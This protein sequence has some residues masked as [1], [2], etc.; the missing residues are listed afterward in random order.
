MRAFR[1]QNRRFVVNRPTGAHKAK[2]IRVLFSRASLGFND[3]EDGSGSRTGSLIQL[4][5]I[6]ELVIFTWARS[7]RCTRVI[8]DSKGHSQKSLHVFLI[9]PFQSIST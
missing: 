8:F 1:L 7:D 9:F 5:F 3:V 6:L 2:K 4:F